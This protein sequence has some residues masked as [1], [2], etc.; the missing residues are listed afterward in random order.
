MTRTSLKALALLLAGAA[1]LGAAGA[2]G[3]SPWWT[4]PVVP[5][6]G[7]LL[8]TAG[9]AL[10]AWG[11]RRVLLRDSERGERSRVT[12][13]VDAARRLRLVASGDP[14]FTRET[15]AV[16]HLERAVLFPGSAGDEAKVLRDLRE[17]TPTGRVAL[18][19]SMRTLHDE[20]VVAMGSP[21]HPLFPEADGLLQMLGHP[22]PHVLRRFRTAR[23]W[24][25]R[26]ALFDPARADELLAARLLEAAMPLAALQ[27]LR[28]A[29]R[30]RRRRALRRLA[31]L[32]VVVRQGEQGS[33]GFRVQSLAPWAPAIVLV[34]G[35]RLR[36]LIPGSV[37]VQAPK[38]GAAALERTLRRLPRLLA[39][40]Q[41]LLDV[42]PGLLTVVRDVAAAVT[43]RP[44][45]RIERELR[46][47]SFVGARD[48]VLESHLRGLALLDERRP[49]ESIAEFEAVLRAAPDFA[50]GAFSL[51]TAL[52]R[53]GDPKGGRRALEE[54]VARN[55]RNAEL[56][57]YV[58]RWLA[59]GGD[60]TGARRAYRDGIRRFPAALPI[61]V[62]YAH[63]LANWGEGSAAAEQLDLARREQPADPRLALMAGRAR[64]NAGRAKDAVEPLE[65]AVRALQGGERA[66]AQFWLV[67]ALREQGRHDRAVQLADEVVDALGRGQES[68]LDDLAE[69]LEERHE[70]ARARRASARARRLRGDRW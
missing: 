4:L 11:V 22:V 10:H 51:A 33:I 41:A 40:Q 55:P 35:R 43:G 23:E 32:A 1:A 24:A 20:L 59:D 64:L 66:E 5:C 8:M 6:V 18:A 60:R 68:Y 45:R 46:S 38:G 29:P 21:L 7:Y 17:T 70:F 12:E 25:R 52:R 56:P 27:T 54:H 34:V 3:V 16:P 19:T 9:R 50:P 57:I 69:Y 65:Q 26:R 31:R 13:A 37:I 48:P 14:G 36:D 49:N 53:L 28:R 30:T 62:A 44:A 61:R 67:A 15:D 63:D 42:A 39:E 47:R 2:A 58:A